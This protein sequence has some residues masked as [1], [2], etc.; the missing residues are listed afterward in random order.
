M[1]YIIHKQYTVM[2]SERKYGSIRVPLA[3]SKGEAMFI[4]SS[5]EGE[6]NLAWGDS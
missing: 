6:G 2:P 5:S 3:R 1:I 4:E